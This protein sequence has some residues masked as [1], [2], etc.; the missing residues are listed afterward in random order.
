[1]FVSNIFFSYILS[2]RVQSSWEIEPGECE[3]E[4][5]GEEEG[6]KKD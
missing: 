1:M 4:E 2:L 3:E 6:E 5:K